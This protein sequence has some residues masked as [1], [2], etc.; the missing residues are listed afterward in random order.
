LHRIGYFKVPSFLQERKEPGARLEIDVLV[1]WTRFASTVGKTRGT[2]II[3]KVL[4]LSCCGKGEVKKDVLLLNFTS[5]IILT[6]PTPHLGL[7]QKAMNKRM[8]KVK[9]GAGT[10]W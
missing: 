2:S 10:V 5:S 1:Q 3:L 8:L 4:H 7:Q 6:V 9:T